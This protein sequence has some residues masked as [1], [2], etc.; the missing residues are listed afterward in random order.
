MTT[1][2]YYSDKA[3]GLVLNEKVLLQTL[4]F[5]VTIDHP[6]THVI[7]TCQLVNGILCMY[8]YRIIYIVMFLLLFSLQ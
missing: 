8:Y 3:K 4:G 1:E 2:A 5:D 7:R 6:H